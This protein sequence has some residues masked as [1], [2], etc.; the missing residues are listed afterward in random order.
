VKTQIIALDKQ[1]D[2]LSVRDKLNWSQTGRVLLTWPEAQA[3][4]TRLD[5]VLIQR[6]SVKRGVQLAL[7]TQNGEIREIARELH[8]PVFASTKEAQAARWRVTTRKVTARRKRKDSARKT[9][10][11]L[12]ALREAAHPARPEWLGSK[13]VRWGAFTIA[14]LA[15]L[16]ILVYV[17]PSGKLILSPET[18]AQTLTL[19]VTAGAEITQV[20]L[21]GRLP[22]Y[23]VSVIVEARGSLPATGTV[24]APFKPA[25]G[26]IQFTNLTE[27]AVEVPT[28][29]V[30][31]TLDN[32]AVR[33]ATTRAGTVPAGV[34]RSIIL[35][36]EA[37]MPGSAGNLPAD[38][39]KAIEGDLG[40]SLSATNLAPTHSGTDSPVSGPSEADRQALLSQVTAAL[41]QT[42]REEM[43]ANLP[44]G[45]LALTSSLA[46]LRTL[47]ETFIPAAGLPGEQLDLTLRLEFGGQAI[48]A[49]DLQ[50]LVTPPLDAAIPGSYTPMPDSLEVTLASTPVVNNEGEMNFNINAQ[51]RLLAE[52][53]TKEVVALI[54]GKTSAQAKQSLLEAL[55]LAEAPQIEIEPGWWPRLPF[56]AYRIQVEAVNTQ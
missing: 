9:P 4:L 46:Y 23:P 36:A 39:L 26:G 3:I 30:V 24:M 22:T 51:R 11:E 19:P 8:I 55:P 34:G 12:A 44:R 31:S 15:L 2:Y 27:E 54:L 53:P 28:G 37:L 5:L 6:H 10:A 29:T 13:V 50:A 48:S 7:V 40:L 42:A 33:F 14:L 17:L 41:E 43:Q 32:P 52:L 47:E 45:D 16:A 21:A 1:E 20:N 25:T 56:A 18:H 38:S 49:A 35:S